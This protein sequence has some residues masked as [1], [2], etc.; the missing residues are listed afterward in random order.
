MTKDDEIL[1]LKKRILELK[2]EN[3]ALKKRLNFAR[4]VP[5]E[6]CVAE[7]TDGKRTAYKDRHDV[8]TKSGHR[9]EVK[10]SH[11]NSPSSS[12][13]IEDFTLELGPTSWA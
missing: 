4:G 7:L 13:F 8:T 6:A 10:L 5:A 11:L 2:E 12:K 3:E 9:L 1:R